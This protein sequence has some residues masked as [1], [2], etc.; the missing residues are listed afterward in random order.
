MLNVCSVNT[1]KDLIDHRVC[2][3]F[4]KIKGTRAGIGFVIF[5]Y[6]LHM[7][8][9][10]YSEYIYVKKKNIPNR[11]YNETGAISKYVSNMAFLYEI[12]REKLFVLNFDFKKTNS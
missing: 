10:W 11:D 8:Y 3:L 9:S 4:F 1:A 7:K 2:S 6:F 5:F 12:Y